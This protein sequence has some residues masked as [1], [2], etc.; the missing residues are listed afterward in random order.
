M[1]R[2]LIFPGGPGLSAQYLKEF[3]SAFK[4]SFTDMETVLCDFETLEKAGATKEDFHAFNESIYEKFIGDA[5]LSSVAFIGH[6]FGAHVALAIAA[7]VEKRGLKISF[8]GL[9]NM[10]LSDGSKKLDL[11]FKHAGVDFS[12]VGTENDFTAQWL[13]ALPIYF[14]RT[15]SNVEKSILSRTHW[16]RGARLL[17]NKPSGEA[18]LAGLSRK[19]LGRTIFYSCAM[20]MI[21][22]AEASFIVRKKFPTVLVVED[23]S[24]NHFEVLT[25]PTRVLGRIQTEIIALCAKP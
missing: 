5:S 18:L 7:M 3:T 22:G 4:L 6:S 11:K 1:T 12:S 16:L 10:P 24:A 20:D 17:D 13:K 25:S 2:V 14:G 8:V 19:I 21:Q 23:K 15:P 9:L